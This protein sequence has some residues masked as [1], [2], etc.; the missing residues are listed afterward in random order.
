MATFVAIT[1]P[2]SAIYSRRHRSTSNQ[3]P[4]FYDNF[5]GFKGNYPLVIIYKRHIWK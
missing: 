1:V 5:S 3:Y 4:S 2:Y